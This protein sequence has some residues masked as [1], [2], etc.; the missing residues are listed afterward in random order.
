[1]ATADITTPARP[2]RNAAPQLVLP[3]RTPDDDWIPPLYVKVGAS[4]ERAPDALVIER[5]QQLIAADF[6][7]RA[8]FVTSTAQVM[9]FLSLKIGDRDDEVFAVMLLDARRRFIGYEELFHGT[10]DTVKVE[11]RTVLS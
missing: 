6:R 4:Y 1:M 11:V 9:E 2:N 3:L 8:S 5:A 7:P 10:V